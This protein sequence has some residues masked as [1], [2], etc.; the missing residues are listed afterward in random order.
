M[1]PRGSLPYSQNAVNYPYA[2]W[3]EFNTQSYTLFYKGRYWYCIL[4]YIYVSEI[5]SQRMCAFVIYPMRTTYPTNSIL[6]NLIVV[7]VLSNI[8]QVA[9]WGAT[10]PNMSP[11]WF[12]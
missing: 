2:E 11:S 5:I 1:G 12:I 8:F 4:I 7:T 6:V 10:G 9:Q 3:A